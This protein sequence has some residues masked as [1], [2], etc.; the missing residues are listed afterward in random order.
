MTKLPSTYFTKKNIR[1]IVPTV[2]QITA[3]SDPLHMNLYCFTQKQVFG[4]CTAK[5]LPIW[6]KV[7]THLLLYGIYL[8]ADLDSDQRVGRSRPNQKVCVLL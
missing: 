6:T 5:S 1:M 2:R 7:C 4:P 8:W 3:Q